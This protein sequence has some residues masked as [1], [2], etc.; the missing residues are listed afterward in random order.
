MSAKLKQQYRGQTEGIDLE[1]QARRLK[2][3]NEGEPQVK[4]K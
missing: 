3:R 1:E 2:Q 4:V